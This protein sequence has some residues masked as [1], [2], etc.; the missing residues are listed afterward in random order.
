M[1]GRP[2]SARMAVRLLIAV[3]TALIVTP[4]SPALGF[5]TWDTAVVPGYA[6]HERI[7]RL[8]IHCGGA[9][10]TT[11]DSPLHRAGAACAQ[12]RTAMMIAGTDGYLGGVGAPDSFYDAV[13]DSKS[14][15]HCDDGDYLF[16][17]PTYPRGVGARDRGLLAC[18][19]LFDLYMDDAVRWAGNIVPV[20]DGKPTLDVS[21]AVFNAVRCNEDYDRKYDPGKGHAQA[22]AKCNAL[23]SFGRAM[24]MAQDF[25]S[26]S[27]WI[28]NPWPTSTAPIG[29]MNPPGLMQS[30]TSPEQVPEFLRY[31]RG[32]QEI[33]RFLRATTV[34]TGGYTGSLTGRVT[35]DT[36]GKA[37]RGLNK[38]MG[39]SRIDWV[40]GTI[41]TGKKERGQTGALGGQDNF[42]RAA[43]AAATTT[44]TA[45][46]DL[47]RAVRVAYP[48]DRGEMAVRALTSDA[49]W[50]TCTVRGGALKALA[51][52]QPSLDMGV[53]LSRATTVRITN[54]SG[55]P[56]ECGDA[57]L[58]WGE[59]SPL[60]PDAI[61]PGERASLRTQNAPARVAGTEGSVEYRVVGD[62]ASRVTIR[63]D[64]P[65]YRS[66]R[67]FCMAVGALECRLSGGG[68]TDAV[69][70]VTILAPRQ[71]RGDSAT[72]TLAPKPLSV[73][74][75]ATAPRPRRAPQP[76][77]SPM[78]PSEVAALPEHVPDL[79]DCTGIASR[80]D[81]A[82]DDVSCS[83]AVRTLRELSEDLC[84]PGWRYRPGPENARVFCYQAVPN[85]SGDAGGRAL[86]YTLV[87]FAGD[88]GHGE[89]GAGAPGRSPSS[90]RKSR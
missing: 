45:W 64:N 29:L 72:S 6:E 38:D 30:V 48:G 59:W 35:H 70:N 36:K 89:V 90:G 41:P 44:A 61:G 17:A 78:T 65:L 25:Y 23:I 37:S 10:A 4:A 8:G 71:T 21:Q 15:Q 11:A 27:N 81:L 1:S 2:P 69:V 51:P 79:R 18:R 57:V 7:T 55:L 62:P 43:Y 22:R 3:A 52:S 39:S 31:P 9:F 14:T 85:R 63:W 26:H 33:T 66:N 49:P 20:V 16:G 19:A 13:I 34:V 47:Q 77:D 32:E 28:D 75:A 56:L 40:T 68:G 83:W 53:I 67:N 54:A 73:R 76:I 86:G 24:H 82:V 12:P 87:H 84:P 58:D 60:P 42:Q 46:G 80:A 74:R 5:G 88:G 50:S